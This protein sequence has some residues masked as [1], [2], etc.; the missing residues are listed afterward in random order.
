MAAPTDRYEPLPGLLGLPGFLWRKLSP[1]G[2]KVA[3]GIGLLL[4]A[5]SV[6]AAIVLV[7]RIAEINRDNEAAA[8]RAS[9]QSAKRQRAHLIAEQR[10][11]EGRVARS[12]ALVPAVERAITRDTR[13]RTAS[14]ELENP[15][16]ETECHKLGR[17]GRRTL[18]GCTA[19]TSKVASSDKVSGVVVGYSYRAGLSPAD[20]RFA[21]CKVG[22][23][24]ALGFEAHGLPEVKLPR[25]CGG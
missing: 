11:R 9:L 13:I 14:G 20:G 12:D 23:R 4:L 8:R 6:A 10:P 21:L 1:R 19:I 2:R 22:G 15:A 24:P 16:R 25:V 17:D 7:P 5:G 3:V 18:L